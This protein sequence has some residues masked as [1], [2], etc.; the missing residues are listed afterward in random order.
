MTNGKEQPA[1]EEGIIIDFEEYINNLES[2]GLFCPEELDPEEDRDPKEEEISGKGEEEHIQSGGKEMVPNL[3]TVWNDETRGVGQN[4]FE[5]RFSCPG[6]SCWS[7]ITCRWKSPFTYHCDTFK[8]TLNEESRLLGL[9]MYETWR[10]QSDNYYTEQSVRLRHQ[11]GQGTNDLW[12]YPE[13]LYN[14]WDV[15]IRGCCQ[16]DN[17]WLYRSSSSSKDAWI[18]VSKLNEINQLQVVYYGCKNYTVVETDGSFDTVFREGLYHTNYC[19]VV[20]W[21]FERIET[22]QTEADVATWTAKYL[23]D[24]TSNEVSRVLTHLPTSFG[25]G[26]LRYL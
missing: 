6:C 26:L 3:S 10:L 24:V 22:I 21:E 18:C 8:Q 11:R 9:R 16:Y 7:G 2:E 15:E 20:E 5:R 14:V 1:K 12:D 4:N 17:V 13:M 19:R 25:R 23:K